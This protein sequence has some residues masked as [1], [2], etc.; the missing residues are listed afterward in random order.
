MRFEEG[1]GIIK[2]PRNLICVTHKIGMCFLP[3]GK[4]ACSLLAYLLWVRKVAW[5]QTELCVFR[6][7]ASFEAAHFLFPEKCAAIIRNEREGEG[8]R[9]IVALALA[10]SMV[11]ALCACGHEHTWKEAT[12]TDPKTCTECGEM[13]GEAL[14]HT[15]VESTCTEP[16]T[17]SVCG[18]TEGEAS[19]HK[20]EEAT[21]TEPAVCSVCGETVM[22]ALGHKWEK[23]TCSEPKTCS[24]CGE[25]EGEALGHQEEEWKTTKDASILQ[26]GEEQLSC[27]RCGEILETRT[28]SKLAIEYKNG[29]YNFTKEEFVDFF[30]GFIAS[31]VIIRDTGE[32]DPFGG[33][34]YSISKYGELIALISIKENS[35]GEVTAVMF[36]GEDYAP[37]SLA[38]IALSAMCGF[39]P[40]DKAEE[41]IDSMSKYNS[42]T[43]NGLRMTFKNE[44]SGYY[45]MTIVGA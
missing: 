32:V 28:I 16:K 24:R 15:W 18:E 7:V 34:S 27:K 36:W 25:T 23:A 12:C 45:S 44:G 4:N 20:A 43:L 6:C 41:I 31:S 8:M 3:F 40:T 33:R 30:R 2:L 29:V 38:A 14:G 21:C 13:E 39:D 22:D 26:E 10:L 17:C 1:R 37:A 5:Q 35:A 11:F 9:K 19:G 42:C